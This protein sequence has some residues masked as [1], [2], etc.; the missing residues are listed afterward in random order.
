MLTMPV[1]AIGWPGVALQTLY[2][3]LEKR[4]GLSWSIATTPQDQSISAH[5]YKKYT[6]KSLT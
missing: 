6:A 4:S 1:E 3:A 2:R 5:N